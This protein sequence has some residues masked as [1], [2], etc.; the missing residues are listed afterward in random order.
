MSEHLTLSGW[1]FL[2][3]AWCGILGLNIFCFRKILQEEPD[4]IV[5]PM[6][7]ELDRDE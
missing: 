6:P 4:A 5:D 2:M 1:L 7:E 3:F